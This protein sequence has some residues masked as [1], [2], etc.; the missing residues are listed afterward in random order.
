MHFGIMRERCGWARQQRAV[1]QA[2]CHIFLIVFAIPL[3]PLV[4]NI[5]NRLLCGTVTIAHAAGASQGRRAV[6]GGAPGGGLPQ[7]AKYSKNSSV[8]YWIYML[9][10]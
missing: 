8:S 2:A 3:L 10:T 5:L 9:N 1:K 4:I 6:D 7:P